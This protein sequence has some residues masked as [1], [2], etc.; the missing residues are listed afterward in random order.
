MIYESVIDFSAGGPRGEAC[1]TRRRGS[2]GE[3]VRSA[4]AAAAAEA[5]CAVRVGGRTSGSGVVCGQLELGAAW[6]GAA[7]RAARALVLAVGDGQGSCMPGI[8]SHFPHRLP[9]RVYG[10]G[11]RR[12]QSCAGSKGDPQ[13]GLTGR[14]IN[15]RL[16][17]FRQQRRSG[18]SS[19]APMRFSTADVAFVGWFAGAHADLWLVEPFGYLS[20]DVDVWALATGAAVPVGR[21][22]FPP[23]SRCGSARRSCWAAPRSSRTPILWSAWEASG[24]ALRRRHVAVVRLAFGVS[25]WQGDR[26]AATESQGRRCWSSTSPAPCRWA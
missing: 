15:R 18:S 25:E 23:A 21:G 5:V 11:G 6:R 17:R 24:P 2:D 1:W 8:R 7:L 19:V 3:V 26:L 12:A 22:A 16:R 10:G 13:P 4:A 20:E 9:V 14:R